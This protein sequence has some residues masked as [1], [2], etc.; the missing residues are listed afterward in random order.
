MLAIATFF[1]QHQDL[2][3]SCTVVTVA[4]IFFAVL[5][6]GLRKDRVNRKRY[7]R[8]EQEEK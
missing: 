3:F 1:N 8:Y 5:L 6:E 4:V 7:S 2:F